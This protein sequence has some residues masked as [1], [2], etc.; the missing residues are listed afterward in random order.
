MSDAAAPTENKATAAATGIM[1]NPKLVEIL[2]QIKPIVQQ[3][4][5]IAF[6]VLPHLITAYRKAKE[7]YAIA[8][9]DVLKGCGW[10]AVCFFGKVPVLPPPPP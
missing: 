3:L 5:K 8:P 1:N 2:K 4:E 7:I 10:L 6:L 9:E